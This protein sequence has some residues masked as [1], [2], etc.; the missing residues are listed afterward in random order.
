VLRA[1]ASYERAGRKRRGALERAGRYA[2]PLIRGT[3]A[4]FKRPPVR[5]MARRTAAMSRRELRGT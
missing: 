5:R 1:V 2:R 3:V 4:S